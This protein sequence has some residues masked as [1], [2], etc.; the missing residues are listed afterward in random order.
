MTDNPI[1]IAPAATV[2]LLQ[3]KPLKV[4]LMKRTRK[5]V[6]AG[7]M[8]VFPG[9][10][11]N[12]DEKADLSQYEAFQ[13][14]A[15]DPLSSFHVASVREVFEEAGV[16]LARAQGSLD[17]V[18]L[19][20]KVNNFPGA[21]KSLHQ[22]D[23]TLLQL[24]ETHHLTMANDLLHSIA[25]WITPPGS[26]RRFDTHFFICK[27]PERQTATH[28]DNE[29]V[30][31]AFLSASEALAAYHAGEMMMMTPTLTM[32]SVLL[33]FQ[34]SD[35]LLSAL[36]ASDDEFRVKVDSKTR[37][38]LFPGDSGYPSASTMAEFGWLKLRPQTSNSIPPI[39]YR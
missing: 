10:R 1:P 2:L 28:D 3:D 12:L 38:L 6:F 21:R 14:P 29:L 5:A 32:L 33:Q 9:G 36:E 4:L 30:E 35:D 20:T 22:G 8:W 31:Q 15:K 18:D 16:L 17:L 11:V 25:K 19:T 34:S 24:L 37:Q 39:P 7:D 27:M 26:P 13:A 23:I